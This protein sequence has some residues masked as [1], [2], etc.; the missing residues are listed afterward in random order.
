MQ[1]ELNELKMAFDKFHGIKTETFE[2]TQVKKDLEAVKQN[3]EA[4]K[5]V[6]K[7]IFN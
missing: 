2:Q 6:K 1:K 7:E 4:I 5:F 3:K